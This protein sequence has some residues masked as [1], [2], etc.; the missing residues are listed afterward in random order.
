MSTF[1]P[2]LLPAEIGGEAMDIQRNLT[3]DE[4]LVFIKE[5]TGIEVAPSYLAQLR[6]KGRISY[7][8]F[9][10]RCVYPREQLRKDIMALHKE[11]HSMNKTSK[12][13]RLRG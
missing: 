12:E 2:G 1:F 9:A 8:K 3:G 10:G 7:L 11:Y 6:C 4:A 5:I 13:P